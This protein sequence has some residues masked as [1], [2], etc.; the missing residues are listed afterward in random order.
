M[1]AGLGDWFKK[2]SNHCRCICISQCCV[3]S[4]DDIDIEYE[5][6]QGDR[7]QV[8]QNTIR[9]PITST[10]NTSEPSHSEGSHVDTDSRASQ[11]SFRYIKPLPPT[12]K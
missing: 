8:I 4:V 1:M 6:A 10:P 9:T 3:R 5:N 12:N 2:M 7:Y 11:F